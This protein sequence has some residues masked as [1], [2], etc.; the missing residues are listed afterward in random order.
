[1]ASG[2]L[3]MCASEALEDD[4]RQEVVALVG[5]SQCFLL[6]NDVPKSRGVVTWVAIPVPRH[7]TPHD[8]I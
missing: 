8:I 1:M 2:L 6:N 5:L 4:V 3:Q 7:Q